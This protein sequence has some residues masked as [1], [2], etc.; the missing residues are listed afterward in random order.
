M[1][2]DGRELKPVGEHNWDE[3]DLDPAEPSSAHA[4]VG[5]IRVE[6]GSHYVQVFA[7]VTNPTTRF[8]FEHWTLVAE[9]I[10]TR[11]EY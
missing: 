1:F 6:S 7:R 10:L 5:A 9:R 8:Y 2:V 3:N 11:N 4:V